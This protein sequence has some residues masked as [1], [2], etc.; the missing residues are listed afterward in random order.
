VD[1][2]EFKA[3]VNA[4]GKFTRDRQFC[5]IG[6]VKSN[7]GHPEAASTM[8][9]LAKVVLQFQDE[10]IFP[11][12]KSEPINPNINFE[13][14]QFYLQR[15]I[16]DW[17]RPVININGIEQ[18]FPRRATISSF[19][20]GGSNAHIILEEY[21]KKDKGSKQKMKNFSRHTF[22][23]YRPKM[24]NASKYRQVGF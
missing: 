10:R 18:E 8:A 3:L 15:Q 23:S 24:R 19:G 9:Q 11:S 1:S 17:K 22:L 16:S 7:I 14:S 12:I 6:S 21:R 20:A 4:F 5:A 13:E 2:I